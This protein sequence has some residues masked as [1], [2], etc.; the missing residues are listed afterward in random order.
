M[1]YGLG[2]LIILFL[3]LVLISLERD[4][5]N[6]KLKLAGLKEEDNEL[7]EKLLETDFRFRQLEDSITRIFFMYE[8]TRKV[9]PLVDKKKIL[10]V[11]KE[12]LSALGNAVEDVQ[13]SD[14]SLAGYSNFKLK[15]DPSLYASIKTASPHIEKNLKTIIRTLNLCL[16]KVGLY[17]TL[18]ALSIHDSLTGIHNRRYLDVRLQEEAERARKFSLEFSLLMIDIDFFKKVN[19]TYGHLVGDVVLRAVANILQSC[20]REIDFAARYGG[21]EFIIILQETNKKGALYV[22]ERIRETVEKQ[23][24]KAFDET[25]RVTVSIG[26][27][28]YPQHTSYKE[29]L[30]EIADKALYKAKDKGRNRVEY[31]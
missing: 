4:R 19:D 25:V 5:K 7:K 23:A 29:L 31:F 8:L 14:R 26:V 9:S 12:E 11:F 21:E 18:Q 2:V 27:V 13:F 15:T 28:V 6:Y 30:V 1:L 3:A 17:E 20:I 10:K 16:E 24:I 22:A